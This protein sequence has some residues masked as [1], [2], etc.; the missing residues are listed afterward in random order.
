M[1]WKAATINVK[2]FFVGAFDLEAQAGGEVLLVA[3]HHVHVLGDFAVDFLGAFFAA[4]ALPQAGAVIEV[5]GN[6]GPVLCGL[7]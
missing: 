4:D 5:V 3:D 6:D 7:S 1:F 2:K